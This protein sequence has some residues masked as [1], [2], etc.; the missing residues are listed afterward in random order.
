MVRP[1]VG[2]QRGFRLQADVELQELSLGITG[3]S[4]GGANATGSVRVGMLPPYLARG[5]SIY[6]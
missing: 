5:Y 2:A 3:K 6:E 4:G 1:L